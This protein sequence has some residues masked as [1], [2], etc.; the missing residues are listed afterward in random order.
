MNGDRLIEH[1]EQGIRW[2]IA[3]KLCVPIERVSVRKA[4]LQ[5]GKPV[6]VITIRR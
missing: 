1:D 6:V 5:P 2:R 3:R 4:E